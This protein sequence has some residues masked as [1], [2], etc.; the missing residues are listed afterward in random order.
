MKF[1]R[2]EIITIGDEILYGHIVDTNSQWISNELDSIGVKT[3]RK[4]TISDQ[5]QD[6]LTSLSEAA[7]RADII[8]ITGGLGPTNDDLTKPTLTKYFNSQLQLNEQALQDI[9]WI[10][11]KVGRELTETNRQQAF[12]PANCEIV[13][14]RVGTAPGMWFL[15]NGKVYVSMPGVPH[16]MKTMMTEGVLPKIQQVF[17]TPTIYHKMVKT[18]G[19]G[20]SWLADKIKPWEE[21]LPSHVKLAY[22][23]GLGEVK[24]RLTAIGNSLQDLQKDVSE[25]LLRLHQYVDGYTYGYDQD[26]LPIVVG[27]LL[28]EQGLTLSTAESCTGGKVAHEITSIPGSSQYFIGS[29]VAYDNRLKEE[30]LQVDPHTLATQGAVSEQTVRE[31]AIGVKNRLGSD[32]GIATSGIAGPS[33]GTEDKPVGTIWIACSDPE[34]TTTKLLSLYKDRITNIRFTSNAVLNMVRQRLVEMGGEKP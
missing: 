24:L 21:K 16:E 2:A 34:K 9:R 14:N 20:E 27:K 4:S 32:I 23:P 5:E 1:V 29:V 7:N 10:F 15:E 31:M 22:L 25:Q 26:T 8:L 28:I 11:E 19:I 17:N 18:I 13:R 33:G 30:L 12:L 3:V 6:I